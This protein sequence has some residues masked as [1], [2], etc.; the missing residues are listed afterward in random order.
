MNGISPFIKTFILWHARVWFTSIPFWIAIGKPFIGAPNFLEDLL[1][2]AGVEGVAIFCLLVEPLRKRFIRGLGKNGEQSF[3]FACSC[4]HCLTIFSISLESICTKGSSPDVLLGFLVMVL[5]LFINGEGHN[6]S[7]PLVP[8]QLTVTIGL[9]IYLKILVLT[10]LI[11][12][13][14][15]TVQ[16]LRKRKRSFFRH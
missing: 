15:F 16:S 6:N 1:V 14:F 12:T 13:L 8:F 7:R 5:T 2:A 3:A 9:L 4:R 10:L 11:K